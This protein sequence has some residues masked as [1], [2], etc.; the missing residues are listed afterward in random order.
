MARGGITLLNLPP[1]ASYDDEP[2]E[3]KIFEGRLASA[4]G[5]DSDRNDL[6]EYG[7]RWLL[8]TSWTSL[9]E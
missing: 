4:V 3:G 2:V 1:F 9:Q 6:G 7:V 5:C 8:L